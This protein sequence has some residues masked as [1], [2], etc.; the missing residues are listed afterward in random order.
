MFINKDMMFSLLQVT[1]LQW[2]TYKKFIALTG[3][4]IEAERQTRIFITSMLSKK[5]TEKEESD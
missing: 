5:D 3:S 4:E 1:E 2:E